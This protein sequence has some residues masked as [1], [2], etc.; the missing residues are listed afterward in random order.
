[1]CLNNLFGS[2]DCTWLLFI[3]VLVLLCGTDNGCGD[4]RDRG[5]GCGC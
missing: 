5:C 2:G 1:M 4:I 3:I